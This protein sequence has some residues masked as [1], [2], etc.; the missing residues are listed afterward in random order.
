[1]IQVALQ[2]LHDEPA[3]VRQEGSSREG[4]H[5]S[6]RPQGANPPPSIASCAGR[7]EDVSAAFCDHQALCNQCKDSCAHDVAHARQQG[8]HTD[9]GRVR[10]AAIDS[11]RPPS[12]SVSGLQRAPSAR[13]KQTS[14]SGMIGARGSAPNAADFEAHIRSLDRHPL[15]FARLCR[16]AQFLT[17]KG[18]LAEAREVKSSQRSVVHWCYLGTQECRVCYTY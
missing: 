2:D 14:D 1:M 9:D 11:H 16:F 18:L 6:C 12:P 10:S 4:M 13:V 17:E 7:D 8:K 3:I 15:D 5:P